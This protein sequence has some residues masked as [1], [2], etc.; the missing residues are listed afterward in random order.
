MHRVC[1]RQAGLAI[2]ARA[3]TVP[4]ISGS[5][6][7]RLPSGARSSA[8]AASNAALDQPFRDRTMAVFGGKEQR[9]GAGEI[10]RIDPIASSHAL[11]IDMI[12]LRLRQ[13]RGR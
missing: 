1:N 2:H 8:P 9:G 5:H 13:C 10:A 6:A 11:L 4:A 12:R 3:S 7:G